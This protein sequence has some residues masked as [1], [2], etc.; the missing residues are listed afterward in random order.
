M[1]R[2][3]ITESDDPSDQTN[4]KGIK[5]FQIASEKQSSTN[6]KSLEKKRAKA[7]KYIHLKTVLIQKMLVE[8]DVEGFL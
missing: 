6:Q 1:L 2:H 3:D 4:Q 7:I 5:T 8:N